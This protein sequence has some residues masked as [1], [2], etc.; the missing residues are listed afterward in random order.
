MTKM[1]K[2]LYIYH[3]SLIGGGSYC[4]YNIINRLDRTKY[5]PSIL[6]KSEGPL[7]E[8]LQKIGVEVYL[9]NTLT[10]VPYNQSVFNLTALKRLYCLFISFPRIKR[11]ITHIHPDIVY[12]NTMMMYPYLIA[13]K[14]IHR[15]AIIHLR[16][17]WPKNEHVYQYK[18]AKRII[19]KY[20]DG[21]VAINATS[22]AMVNAPQKTTVIYDWIDFSE[23]N[24]EFSFEALFGKDYLSLK[25][26]TFTGGIDSI[27]G[28]RE[29]VR[30]FSS[31]VLNSDSRLLIL[32]ANTKLC[33]AGFRGTIA[34]YLSIFNYDTYSNRVKKEIL[35]DNRIVCIPSTYKLK[36]IIEKSYC[37]LSY[38]TIP[39]ANLI[40]AE[41]IY[42]GQI[43]IAAD[44]PE[45]IE[46]SNNGESALLFKIND[47]NGFVQKINTLSA[48]Y[49]YFKEK[50]I[51]G[52]E[53]NRLMFDP[54]RNSSLLNEVY[55]ISLK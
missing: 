1:R 4:L 6:L 19:E 18:L 9:E 37:I 10:T 48:N 55:N 40:L 7:C 15:K 52:I 14:S 24:E 43:V 20:A 29:V 31:K 34:R 30:T 27:K 11:L 50:A 33:Y 39:H 53:H 22:A 12:I 47:L 38:F 35:K 44:T 45:A 5:K 49:N 51:A 8:K 42:L 28:T 23:R 3:T 25:I 26:F 17:H 2:I 13:V 32:G 21:I 41:S 46:Y 16:E 54:L 36:Q